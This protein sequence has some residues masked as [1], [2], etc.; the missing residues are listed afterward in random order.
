MPTPF[1]SLDVWKVAHELALF[2]YKVSSRFPQQE[3][4]GI[5]TQLRRAA[6]AVPANI[7]E[8]NGRGTAREYA[9]FC[10]VAKGSLE[11]ARYFALLARDLGFLSSEDYGRCTADY[12]RVGKMLHFLHAS[13]ARGSRSGSTETS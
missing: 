7:A 1:E 3:K 11:E 12:D 5:T 4:F 6:T 13:L 8:G 10:R 9:Y 2:V